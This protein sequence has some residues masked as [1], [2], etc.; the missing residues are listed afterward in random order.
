MVAKHRTCRVLQR[1][2]A[3]CN[4]LSNHSC[5]CLSNNNDRKHSIAR[6]AKGSCL[7]WQRLY[8]RDNLRRSSFSSIFH[9]LPCDRKFLDLLWDV[10]CC[11]QHTAT[12]CTTLQHILKT[13][14]CWEQMNANHYNILQH[15]A[16]H[17]NTLQ[18]S[19]PPCNPLQHTAILCTSLQPIA[20]HPQRRT[21]VLLKNC[22]T[23]VSHNNIVCTNQV[24]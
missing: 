17:C 19:A 9:A 2:A 12:R 8:S 23:V 4:T 14:V 15:T 7:R 21:C 20:T 22:D 24:S 18:Y 6:I 13:C 16:A 5:L 10:F 11:E 1:V 3:C